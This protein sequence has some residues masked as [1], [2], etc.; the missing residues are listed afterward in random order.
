MGLPCGTVAGTLCSQG[1]GSGLGP[2]LRDWIPHAVTRSLSFTTKRFACCKRRWKISCATVE[3]WCSQINK[4]N[5]KKNSFEGNSLARWV[6]GPSFN[7]RWVGTGHVVDLTV[8]LAG[9]WAQSGAGSL[10]MWKTLEQEIHHWPHWFI[11]QAQFH[12]SD[13]GLSFFLPHRRPG[14]YTHS[15]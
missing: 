1:R 6:R 12:T 7:L 8:F 10:K 13:T 3:T 14:P 4:L 2:W 5:K 9:R 11:Q 15:H